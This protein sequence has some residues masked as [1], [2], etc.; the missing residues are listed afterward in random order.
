MVSGFGFRVWPSGV[1]GA[2]D[3][4]V[5]GAGGCR[6]KHTKFLGGDLRV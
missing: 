3:S 1:V 5:V 2:Y 6:L 4:C